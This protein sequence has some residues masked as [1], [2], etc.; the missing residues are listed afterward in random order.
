MQM[1]IVTYNSIHFDG[2]L[3]VF[4]A[5]T[6]QYFAPSERELFINY[7]TKGIEDYYVVEINN[8]VV[9]CG[10]IN[11]EDEKTTGVLSWGMVLPDY[12]KQ[13][14]G[15]ALT[16]YRLNVM[17]AILGITKGRVR[18]A[19]YTYKFYEK[20]GFTL[21]YFEAGYFGGLFDLYDMSVE[22]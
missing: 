10:G 14:I 12:Q 8:K 22:F 7:F 2:C 13:G 16:Q 9:A 4:D 17:K 3:A 11:Y 18:T 20:M 15:T 21:N 6:P 19:Q 1:N 5:N